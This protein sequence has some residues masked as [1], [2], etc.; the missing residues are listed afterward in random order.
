MESFVLVPSQIPPKSYTKPIKSNSLYLRNILAQTV[1]V[2]FVNWK[3]AQYAIWNKANKAGQD[4]INQRTRQ[5][6]RLINSPKEKGYQITNINHF[7]LINHSYSLQ[8]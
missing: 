3:S 1:F 6:K 4:H 7:N 8:L 5:V 2:I